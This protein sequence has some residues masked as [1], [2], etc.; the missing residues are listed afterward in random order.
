MRIVTLA[1]VGALAAPATARADDRPGTIHGFV[2]RGQDQLDGRVTDASGRALPGAKVHVVTDGASERVVSS[3]R[4]GNYR[5]KV[6]RGAWIAR[7]AR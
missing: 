7:G 4:D 6:T 1:V 5:V 2:W 3:D